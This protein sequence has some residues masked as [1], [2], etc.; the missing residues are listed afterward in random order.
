LM[1]LLEHSHELNNR[2]Q[3]IGGCEW[4]HDVCCLGFADINLTSDGGGN[5]GGAAFL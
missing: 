2:G 1:L 4:I 3:C 5:Q